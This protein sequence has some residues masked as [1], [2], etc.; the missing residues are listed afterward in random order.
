MV[1]A[2]VPNTIIRFGLMVIKKYRDYI[3][4]KVYVVNGM[5]LC[6]YFIDGLLNWQN[7]KDF[8]ANV[9]RQNL[10][11]KHSFLILWLLLL[12]WKQ[13]PQRLVHSCGCGCGGLL[14]FPSTIFSLILWNIAFHALVKFSDALWFIFT[15]HF[16][17][18]SFNIYRSWQK[19]M[20]PKKNLQVY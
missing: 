19:C 11:S 9:N 10:V 2:L 16:Y 13:F 3:E 1:L 14:V 5:T 8:W 4:S 7:V 12:G 18:Y 17:N 6:G 20:K 15:T